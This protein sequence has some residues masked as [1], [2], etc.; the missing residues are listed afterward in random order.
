MS[1][2]NPK[3]TRKISP[4]QFQPI[5]I[6][7][8]AKIFDSLFGVP[9]WRRKDPLDELIVTI[10]SQNT[11]D[12]NRDHA[13]TR[14]R[15]AFSTWNDVLCAPVIEI[16]EAIRPAGLSNQKSKSIKNALE[17]VERHFG[18]LSLKNLVELDNDEAITLLTSQKGI[19]V[20]T[21]A[22][23]LAFSLD[24][25]LCPVDTHVHRIAIRLG[26]VEEKATAEKTFYALR[27]LMPNGQAASFHLN[28]LKFGR[29]ICT[30][31][32]PKCKE[33][34]LRDRCLYLTKVNKPGKL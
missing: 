26:W 13:Y 22:V 7:E 2:D 29:T 25:D 21:A 14:L 31:R 20:K 15:S 9:V 1:G 30:A 28:L 17:W 33:C 27:S 34:P 5:E 18:E 23:L 8:V 24:R 32:S 3:K 12:R 19:G 6:V 10:L 16:E 4:K 11:N